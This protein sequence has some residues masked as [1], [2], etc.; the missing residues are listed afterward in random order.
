M[1]DCSNILGLRLFTFTIHL[2]LIYISRNDITTSSK[3][4]TMTKA[5]TTSKAETPTKAETAVTSTARIDSLAI[6]LSYGQQDYVTNPSTIPTHSTESLPSSTH[7]INLNKEIISSTTT[8]PSQPNHQETLRDESNQ[9][10]SSSDPYS[11]NVTSA[12]I[13]V[14]N[15]W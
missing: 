13:F 10:D 11:M 3:A 5:E 2:I 9:L 14:W 8:R 6:D 7:E 4:E 15:T 12:K 1:L